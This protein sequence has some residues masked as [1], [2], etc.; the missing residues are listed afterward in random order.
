MPSV[1]KGGHTDGM[2]HPGGPV[3]EPAKVGAFA[4]ER[5]EQILS[6]LADR[7]RAR[8]GELA[9]LLGVAEPTVRR[10]V[11]DLARQG[12][13]TRTHGGA[14]AR[15]PQLEPALPERMGRQG[16][17]KSSIARACVAMIGEGDAVFIDGGST[18]LRIAE[19]L[20]E[21][22]VTAGGPT[23]VNVLTNAVPVAQS[24][25]TYAGIRHTLLGGTY[26]PAGECVVGPL[27]IQSIGQF[28]VNT[29]FVGV[30][31]LS[32][33]GFTVADLAEA[34]VKAAVIQIAR[35]VVVPMDVSKVGASDF[36]RV[37][38]LDAVTTVVI[39]KP[40]QYLADLAADAGIEL[41]VAAD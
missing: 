9:E 33:V 3:S 1:V 36:A 37:C 13:L 7:G 12:R 20:A 5:R 31:G 25:A 16:P 11:A 23:N 28:T 29:C 34:Q 21:T 10:D 15:R 24:L 22:S 41:I 2:D 19:A 26:R 4:E 17:A 14:I 39:D 27:T 40:H 8:N 35:R 18:N 6:V 32:D 30:T 38:D